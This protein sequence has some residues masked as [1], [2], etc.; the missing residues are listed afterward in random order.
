MN[1]SESKD[2]S[3]SSEKNSTP[4]VTAE[5]AIIRT[6]SP[7]ERMF[8]HHFI[9]EH[10][11][12]KAAKKAGYNKNRG[13]GLYR[14]EN[15]RVM[16]ASLQRVR[17]SRSLVTQDWLEVELLQLYR[18]TKGDTKV[19]MVTPQGMTFDGKKFDGPTSLRVLESIAKLNGIGEQEDKSIAPVSINI[20]FS[21]LCNTPPAI[22]IQQDTWKES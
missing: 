7:Q 12:V 20:D 9:E 16:I 15:I 21:K 8:C 17:E 10:C 13:I 18:A 22:E 1:T 3:T 11:W 19:N 6:L 5:E 4:E 14:Q 2:L